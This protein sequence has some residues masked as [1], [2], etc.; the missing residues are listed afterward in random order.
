MIDKFYVFDDIISKDYQNKIKSILV[1]ET[2]YNDDFPW[3]FISD[4]TY[5]D[6][7]EN[8]G[9]CG[10]THY[11]AVEDDCIISDF[12]P[13]FI[14]LIQNSCIKVKVKKVDVLQARSFLQLPTNIPKHQVDDAHIDLIDTDHFVML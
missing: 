11:F 2:R 14:K 8:Q 5:N 13:L 3:Y 4:M 6:G 7:G 10:F 1:G 12:H 9:R